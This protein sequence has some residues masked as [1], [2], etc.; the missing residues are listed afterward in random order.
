MEDLSQYNA[1]GTMLR[2]AQ[3]RMLDILKAIDVIARR[4]GITYWLDGGSMLG[5]ARHKG[6]IP[7][8]D[9]L[10]IAVFYEDY[11][12]LLS[13]LEKELP[14]QYSVMYT[15]NNKNF[16]FNFAKVVDSRSYVQAEG[17]WP[18]RA[19]LSGLWVDIFPMIHG[20]G[21]IRKV[22][23]AVYGRCYRRIHGFENNNCKK[24]VAY[25]LYPLALGLVGVSKIVG[26]F[27]SRDKYVNTYGTGSAPTQHSTRH[28]SWTV[29][30]KD[31]E[32]E[33]CMFPMPCNY[34]AILTVMYGDY[35]RIPP[36]EKRQT[37]NG[38]IEVY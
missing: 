30:T 36:K 7:W 32:F 6:F 38:K 19:G 4:Y 15:G 37:H 22:V 26:L 21:P 18:S 34:D 31:M 8:D 24:V 20:N 33:G 10:D 11:R 27:I 9:D 2:S 25:L 5:C 13:L 14:S 23:E 12:R 1:E 3:M 35:M 28:R 16:P 29:P 17:D